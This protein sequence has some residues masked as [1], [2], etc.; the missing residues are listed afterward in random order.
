MPSTVIQ[1]FSYDA[2][3]ADLR[4]EFINGRRYVYHDVPESIAAAMQRAKSKGGFFNRKI[5]DHY[6]FSRVR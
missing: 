4:I 2:N 1:Q 3:H 5:R 6:P